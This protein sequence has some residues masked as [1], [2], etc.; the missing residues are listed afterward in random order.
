MLCATRTIG[1]CSQPRSAFTPDSPPPLRH[2][3]SHSSSTPARYTN[4]PTTPAQNHAASAS[5]AATWSSRNHIQNCGCGRA[6]TQPR[7]AATPSAR[8]STG[9]TTTRSTSVWSRRLGHEP[10]AVSS[11]WIGKGE[12]EE[13]GRYENE[14]HPRLGRLVQ[15]GEA[16]CALGAIGRLGGGLGAGGRGCAAE[17]LESAAEAGGRGL[18]VLVKPG[19]GEVRDVQVVAV[20][21]GT[22]C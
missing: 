15:E 5:S 21:G 14:I 9:P 13:G 19:D 1:V 22:P 6:G 16:E 7:T 3:H 11:S 2:S 10:A 4:P 18:A 17:A 20:G 8:T 12:G